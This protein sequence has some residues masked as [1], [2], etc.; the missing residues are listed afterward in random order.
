MKYVNYEINLKSSC[1]KH[2]YSLTCALHRYQRN[3]EQ[4][5]TKAYKHLLYSWR[6]DKHLLQ[7][8]RNHSSG[9]QTW[10]L[11]TFSMFCNTF[12]TFFSKSIIPDN[13]WKCCCSSWHLTLYQHSTLYNISVKQNILFWQ[14]G[15]ARR[16]NLREK[17]LQG[18]QDN[19]FQLQKIIYS[20]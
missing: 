3:S 17:C 8:R 4:K 10:H 7:V 11:Q 15:T 14:L 1:I 18:G 9:C 19:S 6:K 2:I 20:L 5:E 12:N 13:F 16:L